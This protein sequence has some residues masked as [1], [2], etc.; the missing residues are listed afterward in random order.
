MNQ[1]LKFLLIR[2]LSIIL[3]SSSAFAGDG[4]TVW[5]NA[6]NSKTKQRY[7]PVELFTGAK[8]DGEHQ[9]TF[10][11][12]STIACASSSGKRCDK[13]YVTGPF[14]TEKNDTKIE[15]ASNEIPYYLRTF[16][17]RRMGKVESFFTINNSRDGLV[18][19]YDKRKQWGART[20]SGLGSKFPLGYWQQGEVRVYESRRPT[21]IEIIEL[22]GPDHCLTFRWVIG[23]GERK[24][25]DN[26]YTFCPNRGFTKISHNN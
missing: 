14:K 24:N 6:Y 22:N 1:Y 17:T 7:I 4:K 16:S 12:V 18:R 5:D 11:E 19:I 9:L 3:F 26:N 10:K 8:W 23:K 21:K 20:Y 25:M 13:Y 2:F 15:W